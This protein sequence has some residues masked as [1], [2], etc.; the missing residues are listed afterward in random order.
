MSGAN[1]NKPTVDLC[2]LWA[3]AFRCA[4]SERGNEDTIENRTKQQ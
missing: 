4:Q 2:N 3:T 1:M